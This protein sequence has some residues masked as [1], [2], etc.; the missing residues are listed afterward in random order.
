[1]RA[2]LTATRRT[3][4]SLTL[5]AAATAA[6]VNDTTLLRAIK[7]GKVSGNKDA[8]GQ[9]HVEP[10]E[11]HRIYPPM[12]QRADTEAALPTNGC[13]RGRDCRPAPSWGTLARPGRRTRQ[14]RDRWAEAAIVALR[15]LPEPLKSSRFWWRRSVT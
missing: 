9:W 15:A 8:H 5:A 4:I 2:S 14:D 12:T 10:A 6:G 7:A 1:V 3:A 13:A 11:L